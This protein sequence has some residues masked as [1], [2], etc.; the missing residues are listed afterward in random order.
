MD[1]VHGLTLKAVFLDHDCNLRALSGAK[2]LRGRHTARPDNAATA[3]QHRPTAPILAGDA[4]GEEHLFQFAG[5]TASA[6]RV[7]VSWMPIPQDQWIPDQ[8]GVQGFRLS[9]SVALRERPVNHFQAEAAAK[10]RNR[11]SG[12]AAAR[13]PYRILICGRLRRAFASEA[14]IRLMRRPRKYE[15]IENALDQDAVRELNAPPTRGIPSEMD[16]LFDV[17]GGQLAA[18]PAQALI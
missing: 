5:L 17:D 1:H 7:S 10:F 14:E 8:A 18:I 4:P 2:I 12:H 11:N 16:H 6:G 15:C 3:F 9:F 13:E